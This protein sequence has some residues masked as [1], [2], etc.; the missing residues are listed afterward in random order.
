MLVIYTQVSI[1]PARSDKLLTGVKGSQALAARI[2]KTLPKLDEAT[3][4]IYLIVFPCVILPRITLL[5]IIDNPFSVKIKSAQSFAT[6]ALQSTEI[7]TSASRSAP[8]SL[9]PSPSIPT[10]LPAF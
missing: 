10:Q 7:P 3:I 9:M 1:L 8:Q 4:L 6:P 5:T 2:L